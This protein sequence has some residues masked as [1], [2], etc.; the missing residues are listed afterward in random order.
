MSIFGFSSQF[1]YF[2]VF[3]LN[4]AWW[5]LICF[6]SYIE[7][8]I[9]I[10]FIF[11]ILFLLSFYLISAFICINLLFLL[12]IVWLC[13]AISHLG[14]CLQTRS[15]LSLKHPVTLPA[16]FHPYS[17][18]ISCHRTPYQSS[19]FTP[20]RFESFPHPLFLY[21]YHSIILKGFTIYV[22]EW[23]TVLH[24]YVMTLLPVIFFSPL[25]T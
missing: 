8:S 14:C 10:W 17:I 1:L 6:G 11:S 16:V 19:L 12:F 4:N 5:W 13:C 15:P 22:S 20:Y 2:F 18:L 21:H 23:F 3:F 9:F 25:V 24:L 7:E